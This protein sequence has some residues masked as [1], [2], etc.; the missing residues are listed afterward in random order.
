MNIKSVK[1]RITNKR[2]R[3]ELKKCKHRI[4][5]VDTKAKLI[6]SV[7]DAFE[8]E[9]NEN[10]YLKKQNTE[11]LHKY[12]TLSQEDVGL[13]MDLSICKRKLI[14]A[15]NMT[16]DYRS[17]IKD[18]KENIQ[19]LSKAVA[20]LTKENERFK[21]SGTGIANKIKNI[22]KRGTQNGR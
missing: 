1:L 10:R 8:N 12:F 18:Y 21:S 14:T 2:L 22:L 5:F 13:E 4:S 7:E 6:S 9:Q 15:E 20:I 11:Y 16:M 19:R 17:L 3:L